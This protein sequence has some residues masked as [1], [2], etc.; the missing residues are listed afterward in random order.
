MSEIKPTVGQVLAPIEAARALFRIA[1]NPRGDASWPIIR[2]RLESLER[3]LIACD[4][5][6]DGPLIQEI[7]HF[8]G[9]QRAR[10]RPKP[11]DFLP[12]NMTF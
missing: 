7:A 12:P 10:R 1:R 4:N 6:G 2:Q 11:E 5:P 9:R 3:A 8:L